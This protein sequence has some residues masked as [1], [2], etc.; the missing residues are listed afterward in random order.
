M[1]NILPFVILQAWGLWRPGSG[2]A[3]DLASP[4]STADEEG[5]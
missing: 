4:S 3:D 2:F 5:V 1:L